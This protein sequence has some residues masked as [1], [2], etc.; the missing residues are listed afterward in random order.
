MVTGAQFDKTFPTLDCSACILTP[1]MVA[2]ANNENITVHTY[3][4]VEE[5]TV[6]ILGDMPEQGHGFPTEPEVSGTM[7]AGQTFGQLFEEPGTF[8]YFCA[9]HPSMTGT[10]T[11][12]ETAP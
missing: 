4:E 7:E 3:A 10:V 11:V 12:T 1:K 6:K 5:V 2:V 9:I 8:D